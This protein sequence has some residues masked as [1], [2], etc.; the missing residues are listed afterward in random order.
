MSYA[1]QNFMDHEHGGWYKLLNRENQKSV[2]RNQR[3]PKQITILYPPFMKSLKRFNRK[4]RRSN[5]D[6]RLF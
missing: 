5:R 3:P 2:I 6:H 4:N 1:S